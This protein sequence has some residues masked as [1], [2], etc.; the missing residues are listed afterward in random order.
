MEPPMTAPTLP[1]LGPSL[2]RLV[3]PPTSPAATPLAPIRLALVTG[4]FDAAGQARSAL[5]AG[6]MAE[7]RGGLAPA[8]WSELWGRAAEDATTAVVNVLESRLNAAAAE[9]RMPMRMR[10]RLRITEA[11]RRA[12]HA[13]LGGG[14]TA[15]LREAELLPRADDAAWVERVGAA[16]RR[17]ESAWLALEAAA[18]RE[19]AD[20]EPE[21]SAARSWRRPT[22]PLWAVT[23]AVVALATWAGLLLGGYLPVPGPLRP[24]VE[25][26][27]TRW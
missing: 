4:L 25:F 26:W 10:E 5:A 2:G 3:L 20:W 14:G 18:A 8:V 7:A 17:V 16:T 13:R 27:W 15:M 1:E 21:I 22:W 12:I 9:S 19:L 24:F 23:V 11:E 6:S